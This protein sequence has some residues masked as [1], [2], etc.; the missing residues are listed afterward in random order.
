MPQSMFQPKEMPSISFI[1]KKTGKVGKKR[2]K[3]TIMAQNG[4]A[5]LGNAVFKINFS[6]AVTAFAPPFMALLTK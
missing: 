4:S 6:P 2:K 1:I 3:A 5:I